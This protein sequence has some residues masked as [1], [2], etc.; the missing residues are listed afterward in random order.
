MI[1]NNVI[2]LLIIFCYVIILILLETNG[3]NKKDLTN[4]L[5]ASITGIEPYNVIEL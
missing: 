4:Y 3:C 5:R 2:N 1:V